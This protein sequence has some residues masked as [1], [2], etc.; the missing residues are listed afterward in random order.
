MSVTFLIKQQETCQ[1]NKKD[2]KLV[3]LLRLMFLFQHHILLK[4]L[5]HS[6]S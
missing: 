3:R 2:K 6:Q 5:L 4:S 1:Y